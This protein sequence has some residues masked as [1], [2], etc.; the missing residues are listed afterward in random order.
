MTALSDRS[1]PVVLVAAA[2]LGSSPG[3]A[4]EGELEGLEEQAIKA[5]VARVAPSVLRIETIGGM[6]QVGRMLVSVGP[7]TGLAVGEDGWVISSA[8]NFVQ[9]PTSILVTMP[10]GQRAAATIVSRDNSRMVVLLKVKSPEKLAVPEAVP[11]DQLAVGQW[12]IAVGRTFEG[13]LPNV[14]VGI[15]SAISRIWGKAIQTDAKVSPNNYGGPLIDIRGRVLGLLVPMSPQAQGEMAGAELYD[16]GIG[17]AVPLV[18]ILSHLDRMKRGEQLQ[19]G[20]LG[21]S[22][23]GNGHH[24]A[25][26]EIAAAQPKSPAFK[27]GLRAGDKIIEAAGRKVARQA[28]LKHALGPLYA[29]DKVRIVALRGDKRVEATV[30]LTDKLEPYE[31]P[32]LGLLPLRGAGG[33]PGVAV[34]YVYPGSPAAEAGVRAGDRVTALGGTAVA[35]VAG[36][37][38]VL[39]NQLPKD[40]LAVTVQRG[41][42]TQQLEV[43]LAN[44]PAEFPGELPPACDPRPVAAAERPAVGAVEIKLPEEEH[45]CLA[46]VPENYH[47]DVPYGLVVWLHAPGGFERKSLIERWQRHCT[48]RDLILLAPQAADKAK[49]Q[50]TEVAF[51]R[52]TIDDVLAKYHVD[53][54]R[55][56]V[57][58]YQAGATLAGITA[59]AQR[60]LI[61]AAVLVDAPLPSR[62]GVPP[63]EPVQRLAFCLAVAKNAKLAPQVHAD[64]KRLREI[65]YPV[66]LLEQDG[67]P[68]DLH[69]GELADLTR[70]IDTLDRF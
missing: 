1:W 42:Q 19:P 34:R 25:V 40:K 62:A 52:K 60:D 12:T 64:A 46:Y 49:W 3:A 58:G 18:D 67:E 45:Q 61:R 51:I 5:A 26:A 7:T 8:F 47:P 54:T 10:S 2:L 17:F 22:L 35:D 68:R 63:T 21:I 24:A 44:L 20:L 36:A 53:R 37:L 69:D 31:Y 6:E 70:W 43:T 23:K 14:S 57:M 59:I 15:L 28:H 32:F 30:E 41:G 56:V 50:P 11:R 66:L 27:A 65:K 48:R 39:A 13:S 16:S 9:Q 33:Q 55:I 4:A 29:G 38:Q